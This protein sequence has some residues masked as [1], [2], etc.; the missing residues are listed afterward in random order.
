[1]ILANS[2]R[3][4]AKLR[5]VATLPPRRFFGGNNLLRAHDQIAA[6]KTLGATV[7]EFD[8]EAVYTNN[9][10]EI[11]RQREAIIAFHADAV[12]GTPHAGYVVQG[13]MIAKPAGST[14]RCRNI[15]FDDL[16]LPAVLY[17]DHALTQA[18][19]YWLS[20]WPE[21]PGE[22]DDGALD[23]LKELFSR[24]DVA[25][26]FP[27][28]GHA[29]ALGELGIGSF[30]ETAWYVQEVAK[31]FARAG[32][33]A[34]RPEK[35][36]ENVAFFGNLYLATSQAIPYSEVRG[37]AELRDKA[38]MACAANWSLSAFQAYSDAIG[39]LEPDMKSSLRLDRD[40][41]FYWRFL[42]D[43]LSRFMNGE[44]R[45]NILQSSGHTVACFGNFNDPDSSALMTNNCVFRRALPYDETLA[46]AFRR[47]RIVVDVVNAPFI[48]GFSVKP[49][50]CLASGGFVLTNRKADLIRAL[51]PAANEIVYDDADELA[52]KLDYFL[53]NERERAELTQELGAIVR[54]EF[55][56]EALFARTL[57]PAL[58]RL[59]A[60][61]KPEG[62]KSII[63]RAR[64]SLRSAKNN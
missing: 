2:E 38:R 17:W 33:S 12:V 51:G 1:M 45:L 52:R 63:R 58:E 23:T 26:F 56:A 4:L 35:Y 31:P 49:I 50:V 59:R 37:I 16:E 8:T 20:A 54:R 18:A 64:R 61:S 27:D 40:Q 15:F 21:Q 47:T 57:P 25:H 46:D 7:Y 41:S 39:D 32:S 6:L 42:F 3:P 30:D 34:E 62:W 10:S 19:R 43:E 9:Q 28:T 48:N 14:R 44:H 5:L 55:S 29:G 53:T 13:G 22:S 60:R 11:K 24:P 36:Q